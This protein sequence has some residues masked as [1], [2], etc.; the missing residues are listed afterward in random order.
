MNW[1]IEYKKSLKD[2]EAEELLDVYFYRPLAF[3]IVKAFYHFPLT[4]NHYSFMA[5]VSGIFSA[6]FFAKGSESGLAFG[7]FF[8]LLFAILDCCDGMVAR[9]KRNGTEFGRL[10]DG[11]VD[12]TVNIMVYV[13]LAIGLKNEWHLVILAG[14]SKAIHSITYD[15]YLNEYLS[16]AKGNSG[17]AENEWNHLKT[18]Y[19]ETLSEKLFLKAFILKIYMGYTKLQM[20]KSQKIKKYQPKAYCQVNLKLLRMWS[21]IGP[22]VHIAFLVLAYL[23]NFSK[24]FYVYAIVLGNIWLIWMFFYQFKKNRELASVI[25]AER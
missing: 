11:A 13:A 21:F 12:Y 14:I 10:I 9:L 2:I 15:H 4:P 17:F 22:A 23:F 18:R 6:Y 3:I 20:G 1:L 25:G 7:A 16:Y 24:L 8:F 5:L 19:E